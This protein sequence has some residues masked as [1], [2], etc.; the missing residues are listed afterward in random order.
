MIVELELVHE[1]GHGQYEGILFW[2]FDEQTD[3]RCTAMHAREVDRGES[4]DLLQALDNRVTAERTRGQA[5]WHLSVR[6]G[7]GQ[8]QHLHHFRVVPKSGQVHRGEPS[9][10]FVAVVELIAEGIRMPCL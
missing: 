3:N 7:A 8:Q 10:R 4:V 1:K 6:V 2:T 9:V 5:V